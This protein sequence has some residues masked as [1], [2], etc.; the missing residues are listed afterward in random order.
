MS[1]ESQRAVPFLGISGCF[2]G[3]YVENSPNNKHMRSSAAYPLPLPCF[4]VSLCSSI[5]ALSPRALMFCPGYQ[6]AEVAQAGSWLL[7]AA[8]D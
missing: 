8:G 1:E 3:Q 2:G 7:R 5:A 4:P 6:T